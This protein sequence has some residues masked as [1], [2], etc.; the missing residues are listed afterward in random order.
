MAFKTLIETRPDTSVGF[1]EDTE[2]Y[3][4]DTR[5]DKFTDDLKK[6]GIVKSIQVVISEDQLVKKKIHETDSP[7]LLDALR[8]CFFP[9]NQRWSREWEIISNHVITEDPPY[10]IDIQGADIQEKFT[11][12]IIEYYSS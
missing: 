10:N 6:A 1:K 12:F 4:L 3:K 7:E 8:E 5:I 9:D 2:T 11:K